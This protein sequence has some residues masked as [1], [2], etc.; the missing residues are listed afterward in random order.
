VADLFEEV[1]EQLRSDRYRRLALKAAPWALGLIVAALIAIGGWWGWQHY[2]EQ[3]V[4]KASEQY[5]QA[6][7]ALEQGRA[8]QATRLFTEVS[9]LDAAG[10][11]SLA[12]M[13][14]GG[15]QL[16]QNHT[17]AAVKL[18]DQSAAAAPDDVIGD[19]ARLKSAFALLDTA[20]LKELEG[21]LTPLTQDGHPYR[22][23]AREAKVR[24]REIASGR[25]MFGHFRHL[26][27]P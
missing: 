4:G 15:I 16:G 1:E 26:R 21:R 7:D 10:Y 5:A 13:Q 11:K 12:L 9:K 22:V 8:D 6:L 18:F 20:P 27:L 23:Q 17:A 14:L 24:G 19:V 25:Q 2:R 3:A